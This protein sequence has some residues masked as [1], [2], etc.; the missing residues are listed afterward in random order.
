MVKASICL[1]ILLCIAAPGYAAY[2]LFF[3]GSNAWLPALSRDAGHIAEM[4]AGCSSVGALRGHVSV[5][6]S[7]H[8]V[9]L[10]RK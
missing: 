3:G 9:C 10:P 7:P 1:A 5:D 4:L 6:H 8:A 2:C